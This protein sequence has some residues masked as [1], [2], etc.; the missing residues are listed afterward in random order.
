VADFSGGS[1]TSDA[2]LVLL[3]QL[4][5]Q[6]EITRSFARGFKDERDHRMHFRPNRTTGY[7]LVQGYP[8]STRLLR[9]DPMFGLA[10]GK[11]ESACSLC[12]ASRQKHSESEM[13][14]CPDLAQEQERYVKVT[15]DSRV[16]EQVFQ[17]CFL[18]FM[19]A[20]HVSSLLTWT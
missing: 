12:A 6:Y 11:L 10:I 8:T 7:A 15:A 18:C 13:A 20:H 2:G 5:K 1:I 14:I 9:F 17:T 19:T 3:A 16:L 4:D